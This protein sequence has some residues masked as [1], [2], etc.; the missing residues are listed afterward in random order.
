LI[1]EYLFI[2]FSVSVLCKSFEQF[3]IRH[4]VFQSEKKG[5]NK[6]GTNKYNLPVP[7][8]YLLR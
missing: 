1:A 8:C 5:K 2:S 6:A 7:S 4:R 3:I